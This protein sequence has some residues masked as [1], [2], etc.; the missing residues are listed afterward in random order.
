VIDFAIDPEIGRLRE[1]VADFVRRSVIPAEPRDQHGHGLDDALRA[2]LQ[3]EAKA[4]DIFAP[5]VAREL[6]GLG[7]DHR[8]QAII[9]E[10]AGY[11]LLGP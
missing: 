1:Q 2:E 8:G 11:S 4:A 5:Q 6:G 7:L 9:F 3:A 10:E